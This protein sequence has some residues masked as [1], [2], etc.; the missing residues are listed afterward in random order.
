M[1]SATLKISSK[2]SEY[3]NVLWYAEVFWSWT[4][5]LHTNI[6]SMSFNFLTV[7]Q[8]YAPAQDSMNVL[9]TYTWCV[10]NSAAMQFLDAYDAA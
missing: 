8:C 5:K 6:T 7:I 9:H 10:K 3:L 2:Q 4:I 1:A